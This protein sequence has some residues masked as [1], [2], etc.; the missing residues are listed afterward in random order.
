MEYIPQVPGNRPEV[1]QNH[2]FR[3]TVSATL[4]VLKWSGLYFGPEARE[5]AFKKFRC[6][7]FTENQDNQELV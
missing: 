1:G 7:H 3:K 2:D 6:V 5:W 4:S